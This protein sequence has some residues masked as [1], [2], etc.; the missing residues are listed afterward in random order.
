VREVC[1]YGAGGVPC[2]PGGAGF[3][4]AQLSPGD[5]Y[6]THEGSSSL[7]AAG[8]LG[9]LTSLMTCRLLSI[10]FQVKFRAIS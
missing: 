8:F 9:I 4:S 3:R 2:P 1:R 5:G 7:L 10:L 6:A